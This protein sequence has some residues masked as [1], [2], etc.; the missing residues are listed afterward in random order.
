MART[1]ASGFTLIELMIVVAIVAILAA[2]ALP[3]YQD[4]LVKSRVSEA[5][6]MASELKAGVVTNAGEGGTNLANNADLITAA[7]STEN[8]ASSDVDA[9]NGTITVTTTERAGHGTL[10]L[11][12]TDSAGAPL[13]AGTP[14]NGV[15]IWTC[16]ATI[17]QKYLTSTCSGT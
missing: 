16:T 10:T 15:I 8:V 9:G 2:I 14:P 1:N 11:K 4:Y 6:V 12:P 5:Y 3:A 7:N 17:A 13:A